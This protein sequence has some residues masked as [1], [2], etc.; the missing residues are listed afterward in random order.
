MLLPLPRATT[1]LMSLENHLALVAIRSGN[2]EADHVSCLLKVVYL[3]WF[4]LDKPT[5]D[6]RALLLLAEEVLDRSMTEAAHGGQWRLSDDD[7]AVIE[8]VLT[9]HDRQLDS[10]PSHRYALAWQR[11]TRLAIGSGLQ[12]LPMPGLA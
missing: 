11:L 7:Y 3:A 1:R 8:Q 4:M 6:E 10:L 12:S 5:P 2:G 9:F